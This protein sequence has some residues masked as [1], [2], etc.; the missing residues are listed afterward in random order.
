MLCVYKLSMNMI[1]QYVSMQYCTICVRF[2]LLGEDMLIGGFWPN[3]FAL[4]GGRGPQ[5]WYCRFFEPV[6]LL[7]RRV[8]YGN[9]RLLCRNRVSLLP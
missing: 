4:A 6:T 1:V 8:A 9:A 2:V 7:C 3:A 5:I